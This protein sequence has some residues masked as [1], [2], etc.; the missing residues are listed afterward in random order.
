MV[1]TVSGRA[2]SRAAAGTW[3]VTALGLA[4]L[5]IRLAFLRQLNPPG[6]LAGD[7]ANYDAMVHRLLAGKGY[8]YWPE[9]PDA[10]VTPGF[11]VFLAG[12]YALF[13][14]EP[15]PLG[16]VR[17]AQ[18]V[19]GAA[20]AAAFALLGRR[21]AGPVAGWTTG[22]L[23]A[24]YPPFVWSTAA[25]L[26]EVLALFAFSFFLLAHQAFWESPSRAKG[27]VAGALLGAA[28][29]VRPP[30]A[31]LLVVLPAARALERLLNRWAL[32]PAI[33]ATGGYAWLAAGFCLAMLPWWVRNAVTLHQVV[34]FATQAANPILGGVD[35]YFRNP[36]VFNG[37]GRHEQLRAAVR[38]TAE[39]FRAEPW[40]YLKWFTVGKLWYTFG[41]PYAGG[42]DNRGFLAA[43]AQP[44]HWA[45]VGL[46]ASGL[47]LVRRQR[48]LLPVAASALALTLAQL[49]FIPQYRYAY[50]VM[51]L[52]AVLTG[53]LVARAASTLQGVVGR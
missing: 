11:P 18:A 46:G 27:L 16:A 21:L 17:A 13:G 47:L 37:I 42:V 20:T 39:G 43:L 2:F 53:A 10:Y 44:L 40:L 28:A 24:T 7:A 41:E 35:P 3:G 1:N 8:G 14:P 9:G 19:L 31:L 38:L 23:V 6:A 25:I 34:L 36:A 30:F 4:A 26:T 15:S 49:A 50:P 45:T 12:L 22:A 32:A 48:R 5:L 51:A 29:L 52:L 33:R